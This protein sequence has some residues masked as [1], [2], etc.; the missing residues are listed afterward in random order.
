M[1]S[2]EYFQKVCRYF[3]GDTRKTWAW[4]TT[5]NPSLGSVSPLEMIKGGREDKLKKFIDNQL[6]KGYMP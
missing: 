3:S 1:I 5:P 2:Q 4:F 6:E